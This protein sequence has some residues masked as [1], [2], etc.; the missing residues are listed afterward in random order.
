M[1]LGPNVA[2]SIFD[3]SEVGARFAVNTN[4]PAGK[5]VEIA[6]TEPSLSRPIKRLAKVI[7]FWT[8]D[9]GTLWVVAKFDRR[10][11]YGEFQR[12]V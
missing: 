5:E 10:L 8:Q 1:G 11:E 4:V 2:V 6:L 7:R 9:D 12:L 3:L